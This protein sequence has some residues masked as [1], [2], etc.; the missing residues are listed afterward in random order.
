[1]KISMWDIYE[2]LPYKNQIPMIN[3]GTATIRSVKWVMPLFLN[4]D[5]VYVGKNSDY[6]YSNDE[7][8]LIVHRND[9][10]RISDVDPE[11]L[12]N[13]VSCILDSFKE[14]ENQLESALE[15]PDGMT[16]MLDCSK[17][18]LENPLFVY[19]PD[20]R[21]L[22]ISSTYS[23]EIHW[24][25]KEILDNKGLSEMRMTSLQDSINLTE[26]FKDLSPTIHES[27]MGYPYYIHCSVLANR[28][29]AGHF[30]LFGMINPIKKGVLKWCSFLVSYLSKYMEQHYNMYSSTSR[31]GQIVTSIITNNIYQESEMILLLS[32]LRW[33]ADDSFQFF[34]IKEN[35]SDEPVL[36]NRLYQ[37]LSDY[38][39]DSI[40]FLY[41]NRLIILENKTR[42][43]LDNDVRIHL[44]VFL[45]EGY[46]CGI[47]MEFKGMEH[48]K[49]Y[50]LQA[51]NELRFCV[52]KRIG[53][54]DA[55]NHGNWFL[56]QLFKENPLS[57]TYV[58]RS[59]LVLKEY[60]HINHTTYYETLKAY[61]YSCFQ[62]STTARMLG[63]H[64]NSVSYRL[65]RIQE[66]IDFEEFFLLAN[67]MDIKK[68]DVL[69]YSFHY[70]DSIK[71]W[72]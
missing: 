7:S 21:T 20:G 30:V 16:R 58:H 53:I 18:I 71:E 70:I 43:N 65:E 9:M 61:V 38:F 39:R 15:I 6:F 36:L 51:E 24:H 45:N 57:E 52:K 4:P 55:A 17:D 19:A 8:A 64:R 59:L 42:S 14:W 44:P 56:T 48:A 5:T 49:P 12:F 32:T 25:W 41:K 35:V 1:M 10:I 28:Y 34:V 63:I 66:I 23:P 67:Q 31:L 40:V 3:D 47:S 46:T 22:A 60:D 33:K 54:S 11:E 68:M 2:K 50:Y 62:L 37:K 13:E 26:V 72:D 69:F 29:M 27:K